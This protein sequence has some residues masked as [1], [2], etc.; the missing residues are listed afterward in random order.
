MVKKGIQVEKIWKNLRK[1]GTCMSVKDG[2]DHPLLR[3]VPV[4]VYQWNVIVDC[5]LKSESASSNAFVAH[6][7]HHFLGLM[8]DWCKAETG[9]YIFALKSKLS[10]AQY[11]QVVTEIH[12]EIQCTDITMLC[13]V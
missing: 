1:F 9:F 11:T 10:V 12:W 6:L 3:D 8:M 13:L 7:P 2:L 5:L 4:S